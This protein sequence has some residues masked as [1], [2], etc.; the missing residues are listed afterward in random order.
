MINRTKKQA[1]PEIN[2]HIK[3]SQT[4]KQKRTEQKNKHANSKKAYT[5]TN[6]LANKDTQTNKEIDK[7]RDKQTNK[8]TK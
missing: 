1:N 6:Q 3:N 2:L 7:Y 4:N 5:Q 8:P